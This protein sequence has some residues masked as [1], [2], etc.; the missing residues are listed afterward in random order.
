[1]AL[2]GAIRAFF[3]VRCPAPGCPRQV[4][5][6][7]NLKAIG[8]KAAEADSREPPASGS[9]HLPLGSK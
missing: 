1:M 8:R 9:A 2:L 7:A 3:T 6:H 5:M 4:R